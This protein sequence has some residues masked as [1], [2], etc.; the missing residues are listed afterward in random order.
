MRQHDESISA[1]GMP[2]L[3]LSKKNAS[4]NEKDRQ[5]KVKDGKKVRVTITSVTTKKE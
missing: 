5:T 3:Y 1:H 4:E 2:L